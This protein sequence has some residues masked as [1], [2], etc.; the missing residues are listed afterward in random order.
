MEDTLRVVRYFSKIEYI[1][2]LLKNKRLYAAR[3]STFNDPFDS[4]IRSRLDIIGKNIGILK[5][6]GDLTDFC[7]SHPYSNEVQM[8]MACCP[9]ITSIERSQQIDSHIPSNALQKSNSSP[10]TV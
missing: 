10:E 4:F 8:L 7:K 1:E 3:P 5:T 2:D 6:Y 9:R